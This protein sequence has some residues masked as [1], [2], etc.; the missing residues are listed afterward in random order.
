[1][2][3][4]QFC[5]ALIG[6]AMPFMEGSAPLTHLQERV[7]LSTLLLNGAVAFALKI[8]GVLLIDSAGSV[9][10][11]LSGVFKVN[12]RHSSSADPCRTFS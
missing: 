11:T 3:I 12:S 5:V 4:E 7:G 10:L 2:D 9:V 8:A 6:S 1:M